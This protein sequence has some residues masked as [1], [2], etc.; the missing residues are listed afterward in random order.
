MP[1]YIPEPDK[2]MLPS[3]RGGTWLEQAEG[4]RGRRELSGRCAARDDVREVWGLLS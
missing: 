4:A 2:E 3:S 1:G